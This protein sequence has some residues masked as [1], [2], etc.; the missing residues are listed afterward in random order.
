MS[1]TATIDLFAI[2]LI[3]HLL[4][5]RYAKTIRDAFGLALIVTD[6]DM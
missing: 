5:L 2:T 4:Y 6:A 1:L 3:F